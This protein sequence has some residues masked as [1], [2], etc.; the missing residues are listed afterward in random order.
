MH[1]TTVPTT[2]PNNT[3][4]FQINRGEKTDQNVSVINPSNFNASSSMKKRTEVYTANLLS[5]QLIYIPETKLSGIHKFETS[6]R[7]FLN[8]PSGSLKKGRN[9]QKG[10]A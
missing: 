4:T 5:M 10:L 1:Q 3:S 8:K 7:F 6:I 9:C 2:A